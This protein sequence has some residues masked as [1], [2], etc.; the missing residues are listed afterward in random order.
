MARRYFG[1]SAVARGARAD[2]APRVQVAS[3]DAKVRR[4]AGAFDAR[5]SRASVAAFRT[6]SSVHPVERLGEDAV[7][8][9]GFWEA[10]RNEDA[11]IFLAQCIDVRP[12]ML[13]V[14]ATCEGVSPFRTVTRLWAPTLAARVGGPL[15]FALRD[16]ASALPAGVAVTARDGDLI[17]VGRGASIPVEPPFTRSFFLEADAALAAIW[18]AEALLARALPLPITF[19]DARAEGALAVRRTD[20]ARLGFREVLTAIDG[21]Y[22]GKSGCLR[23]TV[24]EVIADASAA[25][26]PIHLALDVGATGHAWLAGDRSARRYDIAF[27]V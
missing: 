3:E 13:V 8:L 6:G 10:R 4:A 27:T 9:T 20:E 25:S 12:T 15:P 11:R 19:A 24:A 23:R 16:V 2:D 26:E 14:R 21:I 17:L 22:P 1:A 5:F 18:R 7:I